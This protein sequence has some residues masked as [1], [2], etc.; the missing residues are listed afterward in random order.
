MADSAIILAQ[1]ATSGRGPDISR[2][3]PRH[4]LPDEG[5]RAAMKEG[6]VIMNTVSIN[7]DAP[8]PT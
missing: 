5:G 1:L 4:V 7:S 3:H 2:Q 6:T 8:N